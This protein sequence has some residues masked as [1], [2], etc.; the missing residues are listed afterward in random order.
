MLFLIMPLFFQGGDSTSE[1][2]CMIFLAYYPKTNLSY[3]ESYPRL[4]QIYTALGVS[5]IYNHE[6]HM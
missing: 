5:D 1:E 4:D 2:M 3:C 6:D